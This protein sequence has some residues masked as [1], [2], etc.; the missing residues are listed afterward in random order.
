MHRNDS[1]GTATFLSRPP[2]ATVRRVC[3]CESLCGVASRS[4]LRPGQSCVAHASRCT[5]RFPLGA[6][7]GEAR[8][9]PRAPQVWLRH[10]LSSIPP[11]VGTYLF[12]GGGCRVQRRGKARVPAR[13]LLPSGRLRA[14]DHEGPWSAGGQA[15]GASV[16][17]PFS[18]HRAP[19]QDVLVGH[20]DSCQWVGSGS[21]CPA[22]TGTRQGP[23]PEG[24]SWLLGQ[25]GFKPSCPAAPPPVRR[26]RSQ[27]AHVHVC[28]AHAFVSVCL[29]PP[30]GYVCVCLH[31]CMG[32]MCVHVYNVCACVTEHG[33]GRGAPGGLLTPPW[34]H[35]RP[36]WTQEAA[37]GALLARRG[38]CGPAW[39][40][41]RGGRPGHRSGL[42]VCCVSR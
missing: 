30:V 36:P 32:C 22:V 9:P 18:P 13:K 28:A 19:R 16:A 29:T 38:A 24:G 26:G 34:P 10:A 17:L 33:Q 41:G 27:A 5:P 21:L 37:P 39:P 25:S 14:C 3:L 20:N 4:P 11:T 12:L 15:A 7:L 31:E 40:M 42:E 35:A 1:R 2:A 8:E 23:C 6:M